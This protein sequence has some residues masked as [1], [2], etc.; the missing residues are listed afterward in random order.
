LLLPQKDFLGLAPPNAFAK[1]FNT[2]VESPPNKMM[3]KKKKKKER[4]KKREKV[5]RQR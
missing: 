5:L 4:R 1:F 3:M 2:A